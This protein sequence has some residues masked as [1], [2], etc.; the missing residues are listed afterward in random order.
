MTSSWHEGTQLLDLEQQV[1]VVY[2]TI[3]TAMAVMSSGRPVRLAVEHG[4]GHPRVQ[5]PLLLTVRCGR[6]AG[7]DRSWLGAR[8]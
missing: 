3:R 4:L 1:R 7:P 8:I 2:L 5:T 6:F